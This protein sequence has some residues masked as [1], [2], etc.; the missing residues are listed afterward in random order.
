VGGFIWWAMIDQRVSIWTTLVGPTTTLLALLDGRTD[1]AAGY[2]V[3]VLI[4]RT[5][6]SVPA[7]LHGRR[8]S[9]AYGPLSALLDWAA[10]LLK[11]W[12][13][14]FPVRQTWFGRG[15]QVLDGSRSHP[16][17][18]AR[19]FVAGML[20]SAMA[21]TYV[22]LVAWFTGRIDLLPTWH[23]YRWEWLSAVVL[24]AIAVGV[25]VLVDKACEP[26]STSLSRS[27]S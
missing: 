25:A 12:V 5:V 9:L 17:A 6:R 16:R 21:A 23:F 3:W 24:G 18:N 26:A 20:L 11:I 8:I 15:T 19:V 4:T 2:L 1:V 7:F 10:A 22:M 14:F 13:L 27:D